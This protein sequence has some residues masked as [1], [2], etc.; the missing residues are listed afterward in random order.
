MSQIVP[1]FKNMQK[2]RHEGWLT[3]F[4]NRKKILHVE[5]VFLLFIEMVVCLKS[6]FH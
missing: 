6:L 2:D 1:Y 5:F 3:V 4:S